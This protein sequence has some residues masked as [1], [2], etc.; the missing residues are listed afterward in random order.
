MDNSLLVLIRN[1]VLYSGSVDSIY[2]IF[3]SPE[4]VKRDG[5]DGINFLKCVTLE[6]EKNQ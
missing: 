4:R 6:Q 5:E 3:G 2:L 1:F